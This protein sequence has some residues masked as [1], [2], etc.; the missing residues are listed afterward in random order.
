MDVDAVVMPSSDV[1]IAFGLE[2]LSG[3]CES[4]IEERMFN[5]E[6]KGRE[7]DELGVP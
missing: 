3:W 7:S 5:A 2:G 1:S 4:A 6:L